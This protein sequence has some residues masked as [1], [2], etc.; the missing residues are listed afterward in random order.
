MAINLVKGQKISL[1][2]HG[3]GQLESFCVGA[4]WGMIEKK[5]WF[6]F[7]SKEAVDLDLSVG[8]Y[9]SN[10]EL[11]GVVYFGDL[12][13][14]GILHSG[15]DLTGDEDGDDGLD[16]E[17][18]QVKLSELPGNVEHVVFILNSFTGHDFHKVPFASIRLY[19]G[20]PERVNSVV[21]TYNI[22]TDPSF[23]GY[24]SMLLGKLYKRNGEWKFAA[25]GEPTRDKKL[26]QSL[27]TAIKYI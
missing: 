17:V 15:D 9:D 5:G 24:V 10:K 19:E 25:I 11:V 14:P 23:S 13:A 12:R 8:M 3:G 6:G 20:T 7:I 21:A 22:A 1:E 27:K 2:K 16:N 26:E 18:I 4:N